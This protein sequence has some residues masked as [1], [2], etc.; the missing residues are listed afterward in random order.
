M[1][2]FLVDSWWYGERRHGGVW[3]WEDTP[4]LVSDTFPG[5]KTHPGM[6]RLSAELGGMPFKAHAGGWSKGKESDPP[7]PYFANPDYKFVTAGNT[8]RCHCTT[9]HSPSLLGNWPPL[10]CVMSYNTR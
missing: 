3:M 5:N 10:R 1:R 4:E 8:V 6:K 7:N 2:Y 9:C